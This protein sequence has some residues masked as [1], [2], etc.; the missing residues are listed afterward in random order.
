MDSISRVQEKAQSMPR[1]LFVYQ[2]QTASLCFSIEKVDE[3]FK[4]RCRLRCPK[5][6]TNYSTDFLTI[7]VV[8]CLFQKL[9]NSIKVQ[10]LLLF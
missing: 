4:L 10:V 3:G 2:V 6:Q 1:K 7:D 8:S 5:L 9:E